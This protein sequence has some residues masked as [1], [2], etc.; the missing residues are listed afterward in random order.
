MSGARRRA[1]SIKHCRSRMVRY[2]LFLDASYNISL[3]LIK[4]SEP[5][6]SANLANRMPHSVKYY[7]IN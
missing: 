1:I 7:S 4:F 3:A 2:F 6:T 5:L